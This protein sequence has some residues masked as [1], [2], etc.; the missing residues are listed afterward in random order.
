M[1]NKKS[2]KPID[3]LLAMW[4][5]EREVLPM[6]HCFVCIVFLA[7]GK[8]V[9]QNEVCDTASE[10]TERAT[11][12]RALGHK[13]QAYLEVFDLNTLEIHHFPLD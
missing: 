5:K 12:W 10:A 4:Y 11:K 6:N 1:T 8:H 9:S 7:D 2:Q 13:A 3:K